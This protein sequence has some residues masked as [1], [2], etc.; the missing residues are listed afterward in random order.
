MGIK[1]GLDAALSCF[2]TMVMSSELYLGKPRAFLLEKEV[3][4]S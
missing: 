1:Y 2:L 4:N 3:L